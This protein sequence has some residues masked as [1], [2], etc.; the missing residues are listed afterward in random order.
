MG[1]LVFEN[2]LAHLFGIP[3]L[4]RQQQQYHRSGIIPYNAIRMQVS[5]I[6][7]PFILCV[8]RFVVRFQHAN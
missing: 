1:Y 4:N 8:H 7:S 2:V 3:A 5:L 6:E